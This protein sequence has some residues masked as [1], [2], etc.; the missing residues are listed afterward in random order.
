[1]VEPAG[2]WRPPFTDPTL[3]QP[4]VPASPARSP[5]PPYRRWL[6]G[7]GAA[8]LGALLG[9]ALTFLPEGDTSVVTTEGRPADPSGALTVTYVPEGFVLVNDSESSNPRGE[10]VRSLRYAPSG[11]EAPAPGPPASAE[12]VVMRR[13][14]DAVDPAALASQPGFDPADVAGRPG[15]VSRR[16][17]RVAMQWSPAPTVVL[18]VH[19]GTRLSEAEVRQ[20]AEGVSYDPTRDD[21]KVTLTREPP[22]S[23]PAVVVAEGDDGAARWELVAHQSDQGLCLLLNHGT[24]SGTGCGH[25]V[26]PNEAIGG[27]PSGGQGWQFL[28]GPVRKDVARLIIELD[29]GT[30]IA[31]RPV[32]SGSGFEVNF[33][34]TPLSPER[35]AVRGVALNGVGLEVGDLLFSSPPP[36]PP[37]RGR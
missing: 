21:L 3:H 12:L 28:S 10:R 34:A 30:T 26:G 7:V 19:G 11:T 23:R 17:G 9:V 20:V 37:I 4:W 24:S 31:L 32:G 15:A 13:V 8:F 5:S 16:G 22:G 27:G 18:A 1:M 6:C 29:D 2:G 25:N 36:R 33:Y 14:G 35:K